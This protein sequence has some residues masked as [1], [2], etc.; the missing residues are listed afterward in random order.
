ML[1]R[2]L[3][4]VMPGREYFLDELPKLG[5]KVWPSQANFVMF[6]PPKP[7]QK[8]FKALLKKGII[9]RALGSFGLGKCIRVNVGTTAENQQFIKELTEILGG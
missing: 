1:F 7:A 3:A 6:Q 5:C 9:V 8:I 2:S 4:L